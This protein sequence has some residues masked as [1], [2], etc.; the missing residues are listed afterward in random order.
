VNL[1]KKIF[2][3]V[4]YLSRVSKTNNKKLII[5]LSV[6][7][8]QLSAATDVLIIIL[9]SSF[10]TGNQY[11]NNI[12]SFIINFFLENIYLLPFFV[13]LRF[14]FIY[15]QSM[16]L[17]KL[18]LNVQKNIKLFLL[19]ELFDKSNYSTADAYFFLN[20]LTGHISFFYSSLAGLVNNFLQIIAFTSYLLI[21]D[22]QTIGAFVFG[23]ILIFF[24]SKILISKSRDMMHDVYEYSKQS[25]QEIQRV[26]D[27]IFLIKLLK[28]ENEEKTKF[29]NTLDRLNISSYN[30]HKFG[31]INSFFPSLITMFLFSILI[32][33]SASTFAITL[34]FIGVTLRLFQS[35]GSLSGS[36]NKIINSHVHIE[37]FHN[38]DQN[39][40]SVNKENFKIKNLSDDISISFRNT[41]FKYFNS[42]Q[43]IFENLNLDIPKNSHTV[44][45]GANGS[46]K[47]TL[48]GLAAG[49]FYSQKGEVVTSVNNFGYIGATPLIFTASLRENILYGND[50]DVHDK[51]ILEY[52]KEIN[53]FNEETNYNLD[54][55]V[56]NK[57]LSSGQMQKIAFV[58]ALLNSPEALLLDESTANLDDNS[59]KYIFELLREKKITI[60]NST[61]DPEKFQNVDLVLNIDIVDEERQIT[62]R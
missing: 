24:P 42:E 15:T 49:V 8:S 45:T 55:V 61:H 17:Q 38:I 12:L 50:K 56:S 26:I 20:V 37:N 32:A 51:D 18:E 22:T 44:L 14:F 16:L 19:S 29:S 3:D 9:F 25:N 35:L 34:D 41:G 57:S 5:A 33:Y 10:F 48:L 23:A 11:E 54:H 2:K 30:N 27:N 4:M 6:L 40:L 1:F 28:K 39:K 31:T 46:G 62:A 21:T 53:T 58:R 47:S 52:L 43:Y 36:A 7:L 60:L 13:L 59:R